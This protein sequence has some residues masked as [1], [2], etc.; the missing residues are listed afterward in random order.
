MVSSQG[1]SY[2][3]ASDMALSRKADIGALVPL[4]VAGVALQIEVASALRRVREQFKAG[5]VPAGNACC[6]FVQVGMD[7]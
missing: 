6:R 3:I 4:L 2:L 7:A 5:S 1:A